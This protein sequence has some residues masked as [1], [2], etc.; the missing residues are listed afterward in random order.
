M[1]RAAFARINLSHLK[2]NLAVVRKL[3]NQSKIMAVVKADAYGHGML[4]VCKSL[5]DAD[6]FSVAYVNEALELRESGI[7]KDIVAL[8]GFSS[9]EELQNVIDQNI[10]VVI[11]HQEQLKILRSCARQSSLN[12]FLKID[13]GMHRLGFAAIE[14]ENVL[15]E[16][17]LLLSPE[18]KIRVMTHLACADEIDNPATLQ[19]LEKF[20]LALKEQAF[21]QSI[22]NSAGILAWPQCHRNWVRPGLVLYG[23]NPLPEQ[24]LYQERKTVIEL[25]PVMSLFAP[26]ISV[27]NCKKGEKIGYGGDFSCPDDMLI[28]IIAIGYADGYPRHLKQSPSV[29]IGGKKTSVVGRVSMDMAAIDLSGMEAN[30]GE[31]VELWGENVSVA[32][33]AEHA[34]TISYELLC[35]AGNSVG[36]TYIQ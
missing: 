6:S 24:A 8:Q 13:T 33:V 4:E 34:E 20:D 27:K 14:F 30:V 19:Q 16:L 11:H 36:K 17:K 12:V 18:S 1:K 29:F 7:K 2:H 32:E 9:A 15:N 28:G 31:V 10:Q 23:V 3:A 21:E 22:A 5:N 25:R 26:L 35:A